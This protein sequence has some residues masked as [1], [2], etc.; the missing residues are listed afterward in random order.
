V[1]LL[2]P[3]PNKRVKRNVGLEVSKK[4]NLCLHLRCNKKKADE[5]A[6]EFVESF[7]ESEAQQ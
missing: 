6:S 3:T 4:F 2:Y 5:L 7:S 1:A